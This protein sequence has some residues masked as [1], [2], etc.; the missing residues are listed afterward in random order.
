MVDICMRV[1]G[2][3]QLAPMVS[4]KRMGDN[5]VYFR[6]LAMYDRT[7]CVQLSDAKNGRFGL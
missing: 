2:N 5:G 7:Y 4:S 6:R 3:C 1:H